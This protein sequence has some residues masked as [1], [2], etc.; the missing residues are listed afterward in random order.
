V[1][2]SML[3]QYEYGAAISIAMVL[4]IISFVMLIVINLLEKWASK[5]QS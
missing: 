1:I 5:Y 4:L 3:E 2:I